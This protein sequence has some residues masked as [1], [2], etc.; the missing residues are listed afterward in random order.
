MELFVVE[1]RKNEIKIDKPVYLGQAILDQS[2][3][4]MYEFH[5]DYMQPKFESKIKLCHM[6]IDSFVYE[7][8]NVLLRQ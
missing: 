5:F 3:A 4:L 7:M 6:D 1:V 8:D 2:K